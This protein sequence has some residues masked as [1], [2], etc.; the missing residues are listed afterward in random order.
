[1]AERII[2]FRG[3]TR[4]KGEYRINLA[5]DKCESNWVYGGVVSGNK[6]FDFDIIYRCEPEFEKY[7][8]YAD[9][10]GE[11]IGQEDR[12]EKKIYEKDIV[13]I[14]RQEGYF[15]VEWD[16]DSAR[17]VMT[18]ETLIFD[19]DNYWG[20]QVEVCGNIFDSPELL[21]GIKTN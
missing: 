1:M 15:L 16:A 8:V 4:R 13:S 11:Y 21:D 12:F 14:D 2:S 19:F 20:Y 5:G 18:N 17:F 10:V 3:Q 9:T 7:V 6:G